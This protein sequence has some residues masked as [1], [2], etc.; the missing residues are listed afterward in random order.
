MKRN[1]HR[2]DRQIILP[3]I[4]DDG[5]A[6][7]AAARVLVVGAGGLGSPVALYLAAAGV[8]TIGLVDYDTV[9][10]SNL[11]RQ[12]LYCESDVG[13][14]KV[15]VAAQRL[16]KLNSSINVVEHNGRLSSCDDVKMAGPTHL[17]ETN[18]WRLV[19]DYDIVV[20]ACDNLAT[21]HLLG[22]VTAELGIPYVFGAIDGFYGQLSLFNYGEGAQ[23]KRFSDLWPEPTTIA[24]ADECAGP[25]DMAVADEHTNTTDRAVAAVG[26]TAGVIGSL[27]AG[28]AI[29]IICGFGDVLAGQLLTIDLR[30]LE[31]HKLT[32]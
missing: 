18:V 1:H 30:T 17:P 29:K 6:L 4:G 10:W 19:K 21:R 5:Q 20:D 11:N 31:I 2:Y 7:L 24:V 32:L 9:G 26:V 14:S 23:R 16:R 15:S 8:G 12:I 13:L 22:K 27:Q 3:E 28:E 25:T